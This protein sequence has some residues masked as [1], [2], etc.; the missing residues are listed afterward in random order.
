M[1]DNIEALKQELEKASLE[2]Q[3]E[4][5]EKFMVANTDERVLEGIRI[6]NESLMAIGHDYIISSHVKE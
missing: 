1:K 2:E 6:A 4:I 5:L 3:K